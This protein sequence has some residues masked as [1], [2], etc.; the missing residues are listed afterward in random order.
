MPGLA[1]AVQPAFTEEDSA[2]FQ[3]ALEVMKHN[4][5]YATLSGSPAPRIMWGWTG[6]SAYPVQTFDGAHWSAAVEGMIYNQ[7]ADK[8]RAALERLAEE[9]FRRGRGAAGSAGGLMRNWD[10]EYL[11]VLV[12]KS[13]GRMVLFGDRFGA[14]PVYYRPAKDCLV[15]AREAKFI[16]A[17]VGGLE[18]DRVGWAEYLLT[19]HPWGQRTLFA[20]VSRPPL[21][22]VWDCRWEGGALRAE[23]SVGW[24]LNLEEKFEGGRPAAAMIEDLTGLFEEAVRMRAGSPGWGLSCGLS[25]GL[26]SRAIAAALRH[27]GAEYETS[28]LDVT[29]PPTPNP[30]EALIAEQVARVLGV[31]WRKF[32]PPRP[33]PED[34]EAIVWGK[35][36]TVYANLASTY[37]YIRD[38]AARRGNRVVHFSGELANLWYDK[39][40]AVDVSR[41]ARFLQAATTLAGPAPRAFEDLLGLPAGTLFGE[42]ETLLAS[43]PE[44]APALKFVRF[45]WDDVNRKR[46]CGEAVDK[47]RLFLWGTDPFGATLFADYLMKVPDEHKTGMGLY[48]K[49]HRRFAPETAGIEHAWAGVPPASDRFTRRGRWTRKVKSHPAVYGAARVVLRIFNRRSKRAVEAYCNH[50]LLDE[51]VWGELD[52]IIEPERRRRM[53]KMR[54]L[55]ANH[56][57]RIWTLALLARTCR[58]RGLVRS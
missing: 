40:P 1:V 3:G 26:D 38:I 37:L 43:Y 36:G 50:W 6:H 47:H 7:P 34:Q 10:G 44:R 54:G 5:G 23:F 49:F 55:D 24:E 45:Q 14:L 35:E 53:L 28:T 33:D 41:P 27:V 2:K 57:K 46:S 20:G 18:F 39:R 31:P 13:T 22:F 4:D 11:V 42:L 30:R 48:L 58:R 21:G 16:G 9:I 52:G 56:V 32:S 25:G 17:Y 19:G 8:L 15:V 51:R 12:D 29:Y